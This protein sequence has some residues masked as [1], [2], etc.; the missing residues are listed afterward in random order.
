MRA[1]KRTPSDGVVT[2]GGIDR[3]VSFIPELV[4]IPGEKIADFNF[5]KDANG[6]FSFTF[7]EYHPTVYALMKAFRENNFVQPFDWMKWQPFAEKIVHEPN[8]LSKARLRTCVKL[9]TLHIRRDHFCAG[10]FGGM[11]SCGHITAILQRLAVLRKYV[12]ANHRS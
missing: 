9:I 11:V 2:R 8:R 12:K 4:S 6:D 7:P 5:R 1:R 10:H 3:V